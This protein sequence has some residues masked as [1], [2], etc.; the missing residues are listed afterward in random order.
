MNR[1]I[2]RHAVTG[3]LIGR[4]YADPG[5][6]I[7]VA[8][9]YSGQCEEGL[10]VMWCDDTGKP[11]VEVAYVWNYVVRKSIDVLTNATT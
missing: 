2:I 11:H 9:R 1:Y 5:W 4:R 10:Q 3:A 6:A 8:Q 7:C